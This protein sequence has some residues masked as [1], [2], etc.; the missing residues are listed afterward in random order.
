MTKRTTILALVLVLGVGAGVVLAGNPEAKTKTVEG[1]LVDTKCY[2]ADE[3]NKSNDHG[4]MKG[5]GTACAKG[6]SPV[7]ILTAQGK[8][9]ALVVPAPAVADQVGQTVRATGTA[10][11]GSFVP[12]KLEV[13]KGD[14]WQAVKLAGTM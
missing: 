3:A 9:Y 2:F 13:K 11:E 14:T 7:G 10:R 6:G 12:S 8:H 5:C 4:P 1:T